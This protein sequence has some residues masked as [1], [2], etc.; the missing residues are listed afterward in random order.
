MNEH[1][2]EPLMGQKEAANYLNKSESWLSKSRLIGNGPK[3]VKM[4]RSV[5]YKRSAL[6]EYIEDCERRS[7]S[8]P[9]SEARAA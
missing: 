8:Y 3:Y 7:T 1:P 2:R 4:S 6:D 9:G 5:R